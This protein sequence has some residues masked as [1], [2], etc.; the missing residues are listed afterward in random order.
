MAGVSLQTLEG[1]SSRIVEL[2][3]AVLA[4]RE[5]GR[6]ESLLLRAD[7]DLVFLALG[8]WILGDAQK[9]R[10][11]VCALRSAR[12]M[13]WT[14]SPSTAAST[15]RGSAGVVKLEEPPCFPPKSRGLLTRSFFSFFRSETS[16][17]LGWRKPLQSCFDMNVVCWFRSTWLMDASNASKQRRISPPVQHGG[18]YLATEF[19]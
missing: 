3:A 19:L 6:R 16:I 10:D 1:S 9:S 15:G 13:G 2:A 14:S 8:D 17:G 5:T 18:Y 11:A 12:P 7:R 4:A